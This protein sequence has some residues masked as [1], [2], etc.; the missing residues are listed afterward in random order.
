M[1]ASGAGNAQAATAPAIADTPPIRFLELVGDMKLDS[2]ERAQLVRLQGLARARD[3]AA[4]RKEDSEL[5]DLLA[6]YEQANPVR[7]AKMRHNL[8]ALLHFDQAKLTDP[9]PAQ[10][11]ARHDPVLVEDKARRELVTHADIR[12]LDASNRYTRRSPAPAFPT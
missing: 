1:T 5:G 6:K 10:L 7:K 12:A 11:L 3:A 8:R 9:L 2:A 4:D